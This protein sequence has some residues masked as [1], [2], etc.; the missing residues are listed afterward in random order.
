MDNSSSSRRLTAPLIFGIAYFAIFAGNNIWRSTFYNYTVETFHITAAQIGLLFSISAIPGVF[1]FGVGLISRGVRL[2]LFMLV[3]CILVGAGLIGIGIAPTRHLL[4]PAVLSISIGFTIFYPVV[5]SLA[6]QDSIPEKTS[7]FMGRLKSFGPLSAVMTALLILFA[8]KPLGYSAFQI[9]AGMLILIFGVII[10]FDVKK[11]KYGL[12]KGTLRW[13]AEL[14]PYYTLNFL[15]GSRS[16]FFKAFILYLLVKEH[17]FTIHTTATIVMIG[18]LCS[19]FSYRL[20]GQVANRHNPAKVLCSIYVTVGLIF[21][22]FRIFENQYAL[23]MLYCLDSLL[24]GVSV[25]TDSQLRKISSPEDYVGDIATGL[26]LF[27]IAGVVFP[28]VTGVIW[29]YRG[30]TSAFIFGSLLAFAAAL[31]SRKLANSES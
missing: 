17:A 9:L 15:A 4:W 31:V 10:T 3:A 13:K 21:L 8:L 5:N 2:S 14:W 27:H 25:I 12:Q 19:F 26:T 22:G 20:I 24:F 29:E 30:A 16:A 18:N 28:L 23:S 6:L 11:K 1:A 7:I